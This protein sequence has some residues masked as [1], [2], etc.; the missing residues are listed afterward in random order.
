MDTDVILISSKLATNHR[1]DNAMGRHDRKFH[2][3]VM[4]FTQPG[5]HFLAAAISNF[6][7]NFDGTKWGVNG[8][9]AFGRTAEEHPELVCADDNRDHFFGA[10]DSLVAILGTTTMKASVANGCL[11]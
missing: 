2:C 3:A 5:N 11:R 7:Q 10:L 1:I 9:V 8:P 6:L 4:K